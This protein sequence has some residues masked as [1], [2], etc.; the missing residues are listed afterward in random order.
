MILKGR[1]STEN[2]FFIMT[3]LFA[4]VINLIFV[5]KYIL[6]DQ[7]HYRAFYTNLVDFNFSEGFLYYQNALGSSEPGYYL[8]TW[9]LSSLGFPK[10][11]VIIIFNILLAGLSFKT[12]TRLGA[13]PFIALLLAVFSYYSYV[14]FFTAE[15]L[16]FS[17]VFFLM[18]FLFEKHKY[19]LL[20]FSILCHAQ[21]LI[22][23]ASFGLV[24]IKDIMVNI[25]KKGIVRKSNLYIII[26]FSVLLLVG[27]PILSQH[28][29][30]KFESYYSD[31]SLF[32]LTRVLIFFILSLIYSKNKNN[33]FYLFLP[34]FILTFILGGERINF[35]GYFLFLYCSL[36]YKKGL[37]FGVFIT[38][39]YFLYA[40]FIFLI[41]ILE[42]GT[43]Y[44]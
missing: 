2:I 17:I 23:I 43:G 33:V 1:I 21:I 3:L 22:L 37:N 36:H 39:I 7:L 42:K 20:S 25:L 30:S 14:L 40:G 27:T 29:L 28:L 32:E 38:T 4:F 31:R 34:I 10:D 24:F 16:K 35:I 12:F 18:F 6:G 8:I 41:N 9:S 13:Y 44:I 26:L 5:P 19:K 15:R 11:T